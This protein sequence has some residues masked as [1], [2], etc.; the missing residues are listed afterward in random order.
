LLA[1]ENQQ[2]VEAFLA[3]NPEFRLMPAAQVLAPQSIEIDQAARFEPYLQMLPHV[4]GSDGFF[5]A[6]LVRD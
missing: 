1:R 2:V 4:H 3:A 6:V 5:A